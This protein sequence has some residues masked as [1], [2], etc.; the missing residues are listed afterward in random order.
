MIVKYFSL[1]EAKFVKQNCYKEAQKCHKLVT[2][3]HIIP[4]PIIY[5]IGHTMSF[6]QQF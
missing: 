1:P 6:L 2:T 5:M 4:L 3:G